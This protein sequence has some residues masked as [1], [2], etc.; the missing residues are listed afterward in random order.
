M[1]EPPI[2]AIENGRTLLARLAEHYDFQCEGKSLE[3]CAEYLDTL[4]CFE[5]MAEWIMV[6]GEGWE[7]SE[8]DQGLIPIPDGYAEQ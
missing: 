8:T 7:P 2:G 1:Q 3:H 4:R 5:V 6:E